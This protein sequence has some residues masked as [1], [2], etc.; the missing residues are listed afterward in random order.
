MARALLIAEKASVRNAIDSYIRKYGHGD[1]ID[2]FAA[3]GHLVRLIEPNE[4]CEEWGGTWNLDVLPMIPD[5]LNFKTDLV[6]DK[7]AHPNYNQI[8]SAL[9]STKYDYIINACDSDREGEAIFWYIYNHLNCKLPVSRYWENGLTDSSIQHAL[10]NLRSYNDG[11]TPNLENLK[12]ASFLRGEFDWLFGMNL[13]RAASLKMKSLVKVGRVKSAVL[14]ILVDLEKRIQNF[15]KS[16]SY[17]ISAL[18]QD[19]TDGNELKHVEQ[20][21]TDKGMKYSQILFDSKEAAENTVDFL[22]KKNQMKVVSKETKTRKIKPSKL[23]TL[24]DIQVEAS[25]KFKMSVAE[26]SEI[27]QSLYEAKI[28]TYPRTKNPYLSTTETTMFPRML[29]VCKRIPHL[30]EFAEKIL[31]E[32]QRIEAVKKNTRYVNDKVTAEEGH[33]AIVLTGEPFNYQSLPERERDILDMVAMRFL[34]IFLD[35]KIEEDTIFIT[36]N[37]NEF[38]RTTILNTLDLGYSKMYKDAFITN[39]I[40][41]FN[42]GDT[43]VIQNYELNEVTSSPPKRMSDGALIAAMRSPSKY[44]QDQNVGMKNILKE[45]DGIGTEATRKEVIPQLVN[46]KYIEI[47]GN[48]NLIYATD[49]GIKIIENLDGLDITSVDLTACWESKLEDVK[50][51]TLTVKEFQDEMVSF[52]IDNVD[53]FKNND[54]SQIGTSHER[55]AV[56]TCPNCG[57]V[58]YEGVK[59][60]YCENFSQDD[61]KCK[62]LMSKVIRGGKINIKNMQKIL[63]KEV[64]NP[65]KITIEKD[66]KKVKIDTR[67][68]YDEDKKVIGFYKQKAIE[69]GT[70]PKCGNPLKESDKY[71]Y[72][73]NYGKED[74]KCQVIF[75]KNFYGANLT[76]NEI[77]SILEGNESKSYA[78]I[79]KNKKKFNA[80]IKYHASSC[81]TEFI[82]EN[83]VDK[84]SADKVGTCIC[85]QGDI[86]GPLDGKF[87]K[88][89]TCKNGC[90]LN[91]SENQGG[92]K[93]SKSDMNILLEGKELKNIKMKAKNGNQYTANLFI[94]G[95]TRKIDR[96]FD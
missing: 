46:D 40:P 36:E 21:E 14:W 27:M 88:Y 75:S 48:G 79:S 25:S 2:C 92:Y 71:I 69:V 85:C 91:I 56:G 95:E 42:I 7:T 47:K 60:Y 53:T 54:F 30:K 70:C 62:V 39:K 77:L 83:K 23:Y 63:N 72:C 1:T 3:R 81:K 51:G 74:G 59:S 66:G 89:Y 93:L 68:M 82:F 55:V 50:L 87:G 49:L 15:K 43:F 6:K 24:G 32:P 65:V 61:D 5:Q 73:S 76:K 38:F 10:T 29:E 11:Q 44:L 9:K 64:S 94:N 86:I 90:G 28:T 22:K 13:S 33:C 80:K 84:S 96:N 45:T 41:V 8:K 19:F 31:S 17:R 12:E 37:Q 26:S 35:D 18:N 57:G 58:V 4:Y 52:I 67:F 34:A 16:T 20:E 78:L